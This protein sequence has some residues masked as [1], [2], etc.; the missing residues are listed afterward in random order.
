MSDRI[1]KQV[2]HNEA[3]NTI[4]ITISDEVKAETLKKIYT[5]LLDEEIKQ[6]EPEAKETPSGR[7]K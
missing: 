3:D 5:M 6:T 4:M 7:R 1:L 2:L